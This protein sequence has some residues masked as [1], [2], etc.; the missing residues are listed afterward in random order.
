[1]R[2]PSLP[3]APV[4]VPEAK[5]LFEP[6]QLYSVARIAEIVGCSDDTVDRKMKKHHVAAV[7]FGKRQ[8]WGQDINRI[9]AAETR[10]V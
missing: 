8:F 9:I 5:Q 10:P 7:R 4:P 1:M 3:L 2:L 6:G